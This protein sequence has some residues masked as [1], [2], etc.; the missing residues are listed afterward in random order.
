MRN[1][2]IVFFL[3]S[4]FFQTV[5]AEAKEINIYGPGGPH[6]PLIE[7]AN[8]YT[9]KTGIKVNVIFGPQARWQKEAL[10]KADILFSASD[11]Q[12]VAF[13]Q[14]H[15][16][17]FKQENVRPLYLHKAIILVKEGNLKKIKGMQSLV[18]P[19]LKIVVNDGAGISNTSGTGVWEDIVGRMKDIEKMQQIR[20]NIVYFAPNSGSAKARFIQ[21]KD[22]ADAWITWK[23]W[24]GIYENAVIV[25][26]EEDLVIYRP[27]E[28]AFR[29]NAN[30]DIMDFIAFLGL[31]GQATFGKYGWF[32]QEKKL[33]KIRKDA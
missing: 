31:E 13:L 4:I 6:V 18:Q 5:V 11:N 14:S 21:E 30:K 28:V 19:G 16:A 7:A 20:K 33:F 15:S 29:N 27:F 17:R 8:M 26:I 23:D 32:R 1:S 10:Q 3:C 22:P 12:M 24:S 2:I 9:E 25:E